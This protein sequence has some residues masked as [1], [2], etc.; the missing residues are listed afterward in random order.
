MR[1]NILLLSIILLLFIKTSSAQNH[2]RP[3]GLGLILGEPTGISAKY[4]LNERNAYDLGLGFLAIGSN[5]YATLHIDYLHHLRNIFNTTEN[6]YLHYG[7]GGKLGFGGE[8]NFGVRGI[9][10]ID[11][12]S[13]K[14][15]IDIFLEIVPIFELIPKA[16]LSSDAAL[17][18][19][20]YF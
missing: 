19:R 9:I 16:A 13:N 4:W 8:K 14:I 6:V 5:S 10:G 18:G 7:F 17:G 12:Q 20:F 3:F 2:E 11:W 1:K 15:P